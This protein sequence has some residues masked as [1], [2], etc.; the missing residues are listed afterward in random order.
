MLT[1]NALVIVSHSNRV[2]KT[3]YV[4]LTLQGKKSDFQEILGLKIRG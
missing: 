3:E 1:L 2:T 4:I